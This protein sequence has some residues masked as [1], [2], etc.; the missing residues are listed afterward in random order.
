MDVAGGAR[1]NATL[2]GEPGLKI[3][4]LEERGHG[5]R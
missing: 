3:T 5:L 1:K 4:D 2:D